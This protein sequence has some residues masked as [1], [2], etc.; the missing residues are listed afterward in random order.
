MITGLHLTCREC[1]GEA[2]IDLEGQVYFI[3][4]VHRCVNDGT[5]M[6]VRRVYDND[7]YYHMRQDTIKEALENE[8]ETG[9]EDKETC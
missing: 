2:Y 6:A 9:E 8:R 3:D 1:G 5:T 7:P 4:A